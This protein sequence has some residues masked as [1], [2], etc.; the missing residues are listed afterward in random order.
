MRLFSTTC[1]V[2]EEKIYGKTV[3]E[4]IKNLCET[5][6]R[7]FED[8]V[9]EP[10]SGRLRIGYVILVNGEPIDFDRGLH[11][12]VKNG[13][14]ISILAALGGGCLKPKAKAW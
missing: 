5:K 9:F 12:K 13:D 14:T 11:R 8:S 1:T 4:V 2:G 6:G 7:E 3:A 10:V